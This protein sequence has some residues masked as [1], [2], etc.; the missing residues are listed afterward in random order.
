MHLFLADPCLNCL[1][2]LPV[3]DPKCQWGSACLDCKGFCAGHYQTQLVNVCDGMALSK[4]PKPPSA[5]L[6][7]LFSSSNGV[8]LEDMIE[9]AA[10]KVLLP[11]DEC[12]IWLNHLKTVVDNRHRGAQKA[13]ATRRAKRS[14][15]SGCRSGSSTSPPA[16]GQVEARIYSRMHVFL[17]TQVEAE[18]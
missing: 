1:E 3:S 14:Q 8:I 11:P 17:D 15:A 13:A 2:P 18:Y 10:K 16:A 7:Q 9:S 6:K 5:V 4:V 12:H